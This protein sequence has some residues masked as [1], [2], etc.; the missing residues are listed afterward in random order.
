MGILRALLALINAGAT[1]LGVIYPAMLRRSI[2][3]EIESYEDEIQRLGRSGDTDSKLRLETVSK[4]RIRAVE[5]LG[6][7]RSSASDAD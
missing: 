6:A 2:I 4:R 3:R 1:F 5:S 7:L